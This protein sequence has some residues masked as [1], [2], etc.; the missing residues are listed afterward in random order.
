MKLDATT[1]L[2]TLVRQRA[3]GHQWA[4][5]VHDCTLPAVPYAGWVVVKLWR[6]GAMLPNPPWLPLH[7]SG[8]SPHLAAA[9]PCPADLLQA[10]GPGR[11][12]QRAYQPGHPD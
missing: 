8:L 2:Q 3:P 7:T 5:A 6:P 10:G 1:T 11:W 9:V 12:R 4:H